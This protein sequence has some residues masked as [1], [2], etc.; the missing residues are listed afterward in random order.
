MRRPDRLIASCA[1]WNEFWEGTKKLSSTSEKGVVFE[2]LTQLYLQTAPE[3]RSELAHIWKLAEEPPPSLGRD[4]LALG[5]AYARQERRY[6]GLSKPVAKELDRLL[7]WPDRSPWVPPCR[8]G[9]SQS[10]PDRLSKNRL[11]PLDAV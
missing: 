8:S 6:G 7:V 3:Y 11:N 9:P 5:I 1:S 2:R 4:I 10:R